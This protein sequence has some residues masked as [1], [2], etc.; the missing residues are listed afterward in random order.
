[1]KK[2]VI[3]AFSG[4]LDT[5]FCVLWLKKQGYEVVTLTVD[6]GGFSL[7]E[8]KNI[9]QQSQLLGSSKHYFIDGRKDLYQKVISYIIK[10][11]ILRGDVYPLCA[12]PER[13]IIAEKLTLIAKKENADGVVH[14]STGAGNDQVR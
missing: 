5:S 10:G 14:G 2:K 12:G 6:S 11:N 4:G 1:M 7:K 3:L 9:E 13:L 8:Q